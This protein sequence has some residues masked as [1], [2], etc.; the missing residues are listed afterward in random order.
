MARMRTA[1]AYPFILHEKET[2]FSR[3]SASSGVLRTTATT[4][5]ATATMAPRHGRVMNP[6]VVL[7]AAEQQTR[8]AADK[9]AAAHIKAPT[10]QMQSVTTRTVE[11]P[12]T[13]RTARGYNNSC[14]GADS[15]HMHITRGP[16]VARPVPRN[17]MAGC[18]SE[19]YHDDT[20]LPACEAA[21]VKV[22]LRQITR[23]APGA[24]TT[25]REAAAA[26]SA[27]AAGAGAATAAR[28]AA[29][30]AAAAAAGAATAS[31]SGASTIFARVLQHR[32][33]EQQKQRR[34]RR[35]H[36]HHLRIMPPNAGCPIP[37]R[38][39]HPS[40]ASRSFP[41]STSLP[42]WQ[43]T[44]PPNLP[45]SAAPY[46]PSSPVS[47]AAPALLSTCSVSA[48]AKES[49]SSSNRIHSH[50]FP[51]SHSSHI[52]HSQSATVVPRREL[53][54]RYSSPALGPNLSNSPCTSPVS[55]PKTNPRGRFESI[56]DQLSSSESEDQVRPGLSGSLTCML[57]L[58][59]TAVT[60]M[61]DTRMLSILAN[62]VAM[63]SP[64]AQGSSSNRSN[65]S[66]DS[67]SSLSAS[68]DSSPSSSQLLSSP[69]SSS[70]SLSLSPS[71]N[72]S[73]H[74]KPHPPPR[75]NWSHSS[76][77]SSSPPSASSC[78]SSH[79]HAWT[80]MLPS[81]AAIRLIAQL[82]ASAAARQGSEQVVTRA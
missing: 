8:A 39:S 22:A 75:R 34:Q 74:L 50:G 19:G 66:R 45:H 65:T 15:T 80:G 18:C 71:T 40:L 17:I 2:F 62:G 60:L 20:S 6:A 64:A 35:H 37:P 41:R 21:Q 14:H 70:S 43:L 1:A 49:P 31:A 63:L 77:T 13:T 81:P 47:A 52:Q 58:T 69:S 59:N 61:G 7:S 10:M 4:G 53:V 25:A 27:G 30:A 82:R 11:A 73:R 9:M 68:F 79:P 54:R 44:P 42:L 3:K 36:H 16:P 67:Y 32:Q 48:S 5:A 28:E 55:S 51:S 56:A 46:L 78:S 76:L 12:Q 33:D 24:A 26:A 29:A 23:R 38:P 57:M 72:P